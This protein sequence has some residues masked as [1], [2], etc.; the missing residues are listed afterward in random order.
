MFPLSP[1]EVLVLN[2]IVL[3]LP[4]VGLVLE[5]PAHDVMRDPPRRSRHAVTR[6]VLL[7][8]AVYGTLMGSCATAV[9]VA[10][11]YGVDHGVIGVNCY[12]VIDSSNAGRCDTV[13]R[14]RAALFLT[15]ALIIT[16]SCF[17]CRHA[18]RP[19]WH[20]LRNVTLFM[21]IASAAVLALVAIIL[22]VPH[23]NSYVFHHAMPTWEIAI[24]FGGLAAFVIVSII[25]KMT[26]RHKMFRSPA[27]GKAY[28]IIQ[29]PQ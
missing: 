11:L 18:H 27:S 19:V 10:I 13:L 21:W 16:F 14:A 8:I 29:R 20:D 28:R 23:L 4:L 22:F 26:V 9:F 25:Y 17:N 2:V 3:P 1:L 7:D 5:P 24:A 6:R 15:L 12:G